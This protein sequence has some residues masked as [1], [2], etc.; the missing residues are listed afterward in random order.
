MSKS[1]NHELL[2]MLIERK[3]FCLQKAREAEEAGRIGLAM[4]FRTLAADSDIMYSLCTG[5]GA[6]GAVAESDRKQLEAT[7]TQ[8]D[9]EM[10]RLAA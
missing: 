6:R 1:T 7:I 10:M 8:M 5:D 3:P 9:N 2:R 4:H